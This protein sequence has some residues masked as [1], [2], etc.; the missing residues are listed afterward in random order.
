MHCGPPT[1]RQFQRLVQPALARESRRARHPTTCM[2]AVAHVHRLPTLP[3]RMTAV[4]EEREK[5]GR[6]PD[7][8][9]V[10]GHVEGALDVRVL[11]GWA[12]R[13]MVSELKVSEP[14]LGSG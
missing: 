14:E 8:V 5:V 9:V 6:L 2:K 10:V 12:Q 7:L 11:S 4:C 1:R 3:T 13:R